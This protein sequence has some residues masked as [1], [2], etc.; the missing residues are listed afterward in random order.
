MSD[1]TLFVTKLPA[2][3]GFSQEI[4]AAGRRLRNSPYMVKARWLVLTEAGEDRVVS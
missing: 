1:V 2:R 4:G 3:I